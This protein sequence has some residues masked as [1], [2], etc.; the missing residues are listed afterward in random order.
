MSIVFGSKKISNKWVLNIG[1]IYKFM[2]V[3]FGYAK[4]NKLVKN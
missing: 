2:Q 4:G 1:S 3:L